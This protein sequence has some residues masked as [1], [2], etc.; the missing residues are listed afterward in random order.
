MKVEQVFAR[1]PGARLSARKDG[2]GGQSALRTDAR[3]GAVAGLPAACCSVRGGVGA[4]VADETPGRRATEEAAAAS[5]RSKPRSL[6][7]AMAERE[8]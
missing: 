7:S 1:G 8:R 4:E 2:A 5:V 3:D 6:R